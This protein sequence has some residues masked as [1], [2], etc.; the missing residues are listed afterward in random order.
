MTIT[1]QNAV[2]QPFQLQ[3][4]LRATEAP[5]CLS[6]CEEPPSLPLTLPYP[7]IVHLMRHGESASNA[8]N[9]ITGSINVPLTKKGRAQAR[10][11]GRKLAKHSDVAFSSTLH[12]SME[13]LQLALKAGRVNVARIV[14]NP[15]LDERSLGELELQPVRPIPHFSAGDFSYAPS[16]GENYSRV[17]RRSLHFLAGVAQWIEEE[18]SRSG[19]RI[20][21][22]LICSHMGPM[23]IISAILD[24]ETDAAGVLGRLFN[25]ADLVEFTWRRL[26][27]PELPLGDA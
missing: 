19:R 8:R 21:R 11:A 23:R 3:L 1:S 18:W 6:P 10:Q 25:P 13:T 15:Y 26:I 7:V 16:G 4:S 27:S 22:I 14:R 12:R 17:T 20:E 5:P 24:E 9:L 2:A